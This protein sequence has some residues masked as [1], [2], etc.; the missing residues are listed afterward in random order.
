M[1]GTVHGDQM[2][3]RHVMKKTLLVGS[4]KISAKRALDRLRYL[5]KQK[6]K[7]ALSRD[8]WLKVARLVPWSHA[9]RYLRRG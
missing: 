6:Q 5:D 7:K 3:D 8:A 1:Q 2:H 9:V 4:P